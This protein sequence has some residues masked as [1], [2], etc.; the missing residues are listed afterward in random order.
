MSART[1]EGLAGQTLPPSSNLDGVTGSSRNA[2][3]LP[4]GPVQWSFVSLHSTSR[5]LRGERNCTTSRIFL[6][7]GHSRLTVP[8]SP[9]P[10]GLRRRTSP[11]YSP[12]PIS[13][14]YEVPVWKSS[15][16]FA[17]LA[18]EETFPPNE[19]SRH[20][21]SLPLRQ[22]GR[23]G[24]WITRF[25]FHPPLV[26]LLLPRCRRCWC[27]YLLRSSLLRHPV[28]SEA[29][30]VNIQLRCYCRC[31]LLRSSRPCHKINYFFFLHVEILFTDTPPPGGGEGGLCGTQVKISHTH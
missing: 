7:M 17:L 6:R 20:R 4:E 16:L 25:C 26:V 30:G 31:S 15:L 9:S 29:R 8:L 22:G 14:R 12:P 2:V 21:P 24:L 10:R 1:S 19:S 23:S 18:C 3:P 13:P 28:P 11:P 5:T 27:G